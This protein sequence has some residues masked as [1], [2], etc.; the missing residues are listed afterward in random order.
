M[1]GFQIKPFGKRNLVC[2]V[3]KQ[4]NIKLISLID[5]LDIQSL[6]K[7]EGCIAFG[8]IEKKRNV[9]QIDSLKKIM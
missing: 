5:D 2:L 9:D 4:K 8:I 3:K 7:L 6:L 1:V